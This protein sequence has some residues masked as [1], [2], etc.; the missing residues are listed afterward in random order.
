MSIIAIDPGR[1][2][3]F[4]MFCRRRTKNNDRVCTARSFAV[5]SRGCD[6]N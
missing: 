3:V 6:V 2:W 4:M 5:G 1:M